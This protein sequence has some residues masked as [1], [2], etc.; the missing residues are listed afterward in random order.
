M[1]EMRALAWRV[2]QLGARPVLRRHHFKRPGGGSMFFRDRG[3]LRQ[4]ITFHRSWRGATGKLRIRVDQRLERHVL[5]SV[6]PCEVDLDLEHG[7]AE[8]AAVHVGYWLEQHLLRQLE[9]ELDLVELARAYE[10]R[11]TGYAREQAA[12]C[13]ELW[14]LLARP[15]EAA[16]VL[17]AIPPE[18]VLFDGEIPF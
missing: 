5:W 4:V 12:Q 8:D 1:N 18:V 7:D 13:A 3:C 6:P 10:L 11:P 16:R 15:E 9:I 14:E 17:A 2:I